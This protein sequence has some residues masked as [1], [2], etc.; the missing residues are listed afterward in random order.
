MAIGR[1]GIRRAAGAWGLVALV[2]ASWAAGWASA[3]EIQPAAAGREHWAFRPV[4]AVAP[5]EVRDAAWAR[6]EVDRFVLAKLEEKG[7]KP[8]ALADRRT[9]IRRA[10]FDLVGLPPGPAEVEAFVKDESGE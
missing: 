5:P 1:R 10:Y 8:A 4:R 3:E 9:L 7:L 6:N 2:L